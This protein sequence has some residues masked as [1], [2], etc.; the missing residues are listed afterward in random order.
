MRFRFIVRLRY[1]MGVHSYG[2]RRNVGSI[3]TV[4][5]AISEVLNFVKLFSCSSEE[6]TIVVY[7]NMLAMVHVVGHSNIQL[8][9]LHPI[10]VLP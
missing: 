7:D 3:C 4:Q 6:I 5:K 1:D 8:S 2:P 10:L 9:S